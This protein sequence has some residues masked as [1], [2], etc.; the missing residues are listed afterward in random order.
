MKKCFSVLLCFVLYFHLFPNL[1]FATDLLMLSC[2][3]KPNTFLK[4]STVTDVAVKSFFLAEFHDYTSMSTTRMN[5]PDNFLQLYS[6]FMTVLAFDV[7]FFISVFLLFRV[8]RR[9]LKG[10]GARR[11]RQKAAV[12]YYRYLTKKRKKS[13][14]V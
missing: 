13:R 11:R 10:Y 1:A 9:F 2:S 14:C 3:N 4:S 6:A 12:R 5:H 7:L 8:I